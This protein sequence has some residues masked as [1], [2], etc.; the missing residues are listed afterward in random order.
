M[1]ITYLDFFSDFFNDY[2]LT[3]A[4]SELSEEIHEN[5]QWDFILQQRTENLS[6]RVSSGSR[7]LQ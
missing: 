6:R 2:H 5:V 1:K 7:S 3:I 4:I